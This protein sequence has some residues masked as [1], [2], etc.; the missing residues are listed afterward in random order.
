M[1]RLFSSLLL[2][3]F[4]GFAAPLFLVGSLLAAFGGVSYI[5]G[6]ACFGS[7]GTAGVVEFLRIFGGGYPW[8]GVFTL[9]LISGIVGGAFDLF[10][11]YIYQGLRGD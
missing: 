1:P 4:L 10:N 6:I 9:G 3:A 11:S 8:Q 2:A 7:G 5:P